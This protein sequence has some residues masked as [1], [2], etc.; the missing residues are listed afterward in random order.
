MQSSILPE[1]SFRISFIAC[2]LNGHSD[3]KF[4]ATLNIRSKLMTIRGS[5]VS[6]K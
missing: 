5:Q 4:V 1:L 2:S 3:P 6:R